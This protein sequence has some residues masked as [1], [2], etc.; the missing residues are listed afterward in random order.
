M[1]LKRPVNSDPHWSSPS[2]LG[3]HCPVVLD[4][5]LG[6]RLCTSVFDSLDR[7]SSRPNRVPV[8]PIPAA[9]VSAIGSVAREG[10]SST[11]A[12]FPTAAIS[13]E[14]ERTRSSLAVSAVKARRSPARKKDVARRSSGRRTHDTRI[15]MRVA[16]ARQRRDPAR[17]RGVHARVSLIDPE[18]LGSLRPPQTPVRH[19][20]SS[21]RD[22]SR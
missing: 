9:F 4:R 22:H 6:N 12:P 8:S 3:A 10:S 17:R 7:R 20:R 16:D 5:P 18:G 2:P 11:R 1:D 13:S 19:S 21:Q 15:S 14:V